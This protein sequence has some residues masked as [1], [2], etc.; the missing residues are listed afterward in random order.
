MNPPHHPRKANG[1]AGYL[2]TVMLVI[3]G[4]W[5][6]CSA[7]IRALNYDTPSWIEVE[8]S[9]IHAKE[10]NTSVTL[11]LFRTGEFR[12][13]TRVDYQTVDQSA[14]GGRDFQAMGG[15]LV[16]QPGEGFKTLT[17]TLRAD[18][19]AEG[20]ETFLL[21][22]SSAD[23]G[24]VIARD[25]V[26]VTIQDASVS[27]ALRIAAKADGTLQ[28]SWQGYPK[29]T[30]ESADC[31]DRAGWSAVAGPVEEVDGVCQVTIPKD[32]AHGFY[33]LRTDD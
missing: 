27:P 30:L 6:A 22:L 11:N 3:F 8:T 2:L 24:T 5:P 32:A 18:E 14:V 33:R 7:Q 25:T 13:T 15:T 20:D 17:L 19:E 4:P 28:L 1:T 12:V 10:G 16:F 23:P 29:A 9:E 21:R 26:K 31:C